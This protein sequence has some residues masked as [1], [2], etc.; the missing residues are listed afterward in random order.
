TL[1]QYSG[2][3]DKGLPAVAR[4]TFGFYFAGHNSRGSLV[5]AYNWGN[6]FDTLDGSNWMYVWNTPFDVI[7]MP[8]AEGLREAWDE[9]RLL[10]TLKRRAEE[11]NVDLSDFLAGLFSEVAAGRGRGGR[12]TLDDFWERAKDDQVMDKWHKRMVEKLLSLD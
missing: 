3:S 11:K 10:E 2:T 7:P 1:W 9:R 8:Y 5:W 4:Y 12:S 6:R